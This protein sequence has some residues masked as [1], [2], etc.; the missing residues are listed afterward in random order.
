[1]SKDSRITSPSLKRGEGDGEREESFGAQGVCKDAVTPVGQLLRPIIFGETMRA[2]T[3]PLA[4]EIIS[5][6]CAQLPL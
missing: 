5:R 6:V 4:T 2:A 3:E 1:M